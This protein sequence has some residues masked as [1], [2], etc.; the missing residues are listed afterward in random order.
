MGSTHQD[1][2]KRLVIALG[3]NAI[4]RAGELGTIQEQF[5]HAEE[6]MGP[7]AELAAAGHSLIITHGNGPVVGNIVLRGEAARNEVPPMPLYIA[8]AD[9][10]GG[11]GLM[12]Q[13]ALHNQMMKLG[14]RRPVATLVT[15]TVVDEHDMAFSRPQKPIGPFISAVDANMRAEHDGWH[16]A[17]FPGRGWRRVVAS[18]RPQR[19]IEIDTVTHLA[20]RG[21]IVIAAGGGG[22]PVAE[23]PDGTLHGV[24]AVI[25]KDWTGALLA[26]AMGADAFAIMMESDAVYLD[27]GL[28]SQR[29]IGTITT[30][31]ADALLADGTFE[32]G[33]MAPKMSAAAYATATCGCDS[34]LVG[35]SALLQAIESGAGTRIVRG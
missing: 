20:D 31:E 8:G 11:L 34:F 18:P 9:S 21:V 35:P 30:R 28:A 29:A 27:Y 23:S 16:V 32:A 25:D 15:Q 13:Q 4:L 22:V 3:G 6:A 17:E 7:V 2:P 12:L 5:H 26:C 24:D 19:I 33:T 1:S 14:L 10:E